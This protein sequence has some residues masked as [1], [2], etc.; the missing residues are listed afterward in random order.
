MNK[1]GYYG[2]FFE[3][4]TVG[5][6]IKHKLG[7]TVTYDDNLF[8][9]HAQLNSA[10]LHFDIEYMAM[11]QFGKPILVATTALMLS[12][13]IS[14]EEFPNIAEE[15]SI[16]NLVFKTPLF[17]MDT[18]HLYSE[19]TG[20]KEVEGWDDAGLVKIHHMV[21]KEQGTKLICEFDRKVMMYKSSN[22]PWE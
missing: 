2:L 7:R 11:S 20:K 4:L 22:S 1:N 16:E 13:G 6:K 18:I 3:D 17:H 9:T 10:P 21:K 15:I 14:S 19:I 12:Y 5:M 8:F